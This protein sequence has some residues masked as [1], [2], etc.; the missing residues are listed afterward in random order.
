MQKVN[1]KIN[2]EL[3]KNITSPPSKALNRKKIGTE[4]KKKERIQGEMIKSSSGVIPIVV[5][6]ENK[7]KN[8]SSQALLV[9]QEKKMIQKKK[10]TQ[11][12]YINASEF[13][14][15]SSKAKRKEKEGSVKQ[16]KSV[17][18]VKNNESEIEKSLS[19]YME[20]VPKS[21]TRLPLLQSSKNMIKALK[22]DKKRQGLDK[23]KN[24]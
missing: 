10:K 16:Q 22:F 12:D 20:L 5:H 7:L 6:G 21:P 17:Q 19:P 13:A 11:M 9:V 3:P 23:P 15:P 8:A 14:S 1:L 24:K 18:N 2:T 4:V